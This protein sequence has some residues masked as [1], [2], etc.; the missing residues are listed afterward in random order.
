MPW[1]FILVM[2]CMGWGLVWDVS[3]VKLELTAET[4]ITLGSLHTE[5]GLATKAMAAAAGG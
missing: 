5:D 3:E 2:P 4:D 1:V